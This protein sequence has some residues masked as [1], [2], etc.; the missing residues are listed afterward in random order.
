MFAK[1]FLAACVKKKTPQKKN[2]KNKKK[3]NKDKNRN[4]QKNKKQPRKKQQQNHLQYINENYAFIL[5]SLGH[6]WKHSI[7]G[8]RLCYK[9]MAYSNLGLSSIHMLY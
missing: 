8:S 3:K 1:T 6:S 9:R 7:N 4:K 5:Q 2:K